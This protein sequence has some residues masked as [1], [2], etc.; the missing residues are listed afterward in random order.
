ML[1]K[2][3]SPSSVN[4]PL[5]SDLFYLIAIKVKQVDDKYFLFPV[6]TAVI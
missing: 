4:F 1:Y 3:I 6:Y 2:D 5:R